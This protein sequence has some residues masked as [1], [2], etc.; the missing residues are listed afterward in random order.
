MAT[1]LSFD[2]ILASN[3][4]STGES[5]ARNVRMVR[6]GRLFPGAE[7]CRCSILGFMNELP[8]RDSPDY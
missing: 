4:M 6:M 1:R 3:A 5:S 2:T 7:D 8:P